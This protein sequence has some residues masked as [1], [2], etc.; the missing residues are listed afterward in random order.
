MADMFS[1]SDLAAMSE[2][3]CAIDPEGRF[4]PGK[5]FPTPRLCGDK[6]GKYVAHPTELSG[7]AGRG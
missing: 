3:R 5:V 6:P 4:N 7:Q 1:E 2:V